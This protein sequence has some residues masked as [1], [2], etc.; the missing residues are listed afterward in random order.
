MGWDYAHR[1][2]FYHDQSRNPHNGSKSKPKQ[3]GIPT[4][5][6]PVHVQGSHLIAVARHETNDT[7]KIFYSDD[8]NNFE[9]EEYVKGMFIQKCMESAFYPSNTEWINIKSTTF[10]PHSNEC[11]PYT[12][13]ALT[14][15]GLHPY[16]HPFMLTPIM[17]PNLAQ[18]L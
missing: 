16:P 8:L 9:T 15:M 14:I 17:H 12:L 3:H 1:K 7:T 18:I 2:F 5:L 11:G 13:L 10:T 4:I 6:I